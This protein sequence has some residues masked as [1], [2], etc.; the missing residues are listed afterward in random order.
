[1]LTRIQRTLVDRLGLGPSTVGARAESGRSR[2]E[3]LAY[4]TQATP[5]AW[6]Q[7][8]WKWNWDSGIKPLQWIIRQPRCDRG[9]A[10]LIYW[11]SGPRYLA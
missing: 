3:L 10:L 11:Y 4:L 7:V 2:A 6:H 5:D 9:T 1:M 8:A